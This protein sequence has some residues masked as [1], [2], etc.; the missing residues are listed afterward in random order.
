VQGIFTKIKNNC[1]A[2]NNPLPSTSVARI[3]FWKWMMEKM[4]RLNS[5]ISVIGT[6]S[7]KI[8]MDKEVI[9]KQALKV[10]HELMMEKSGEGFEVSRS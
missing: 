9:T 6:R 10:Y 4:K 2:A 3:P 8:D 1:E 5:I 7:K